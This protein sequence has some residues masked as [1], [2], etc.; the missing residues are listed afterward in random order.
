MAYGYSFDAW[1]G[2]GKESVWGT[3]VPRTRFYGIESSS[4]KYEATKTYSKELRSRDPRCGNTT[5]SRGVGD[6]VVTPYYEGLGML[7][8]AAL[9]GSKSKQLVA[10]ANLW[11]FSRT[12]TSG[13][14]AQVP[15]G[16]TIEENLGLES[17]L[18]GGVVVNQATLKCPA[19]DYPS[20]SLSCASKSVALNATP[21]TPTFTSDSLIVQ[22]SQCSVSVGGTDFSAMVENVEITWGNSLDLEASC[23]GST[24][25]R[26]PLVKGRADCTAKL[27]LK[28]SDASKSLVASFLSGA[29]VGL[30]VKYVGAAIGATAYNYT[31]MVELPT[32]VI[33][34]G[35]PAPSSEGPLPLDVNLTAVATASGSSWDDATCGMGGALR[36]S[37]QSSL[38]T[39]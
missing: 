5:R 31:L 6:I 38:A 29:T 30:K 34:D 24:N 12:N 27:S 10:G 1:I 28:Y 18:Y 33:S 25:I 9:F 4:L 20:L 14:Y 2:A 8:E 23:F 3:T 22:P 26:Q 32:C 17:Y 35:F 21:S 19:N 7:L 13:N 36:V 39:L 16:L 11:Q 37:V 15:A